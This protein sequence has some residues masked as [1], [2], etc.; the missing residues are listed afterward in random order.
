LKELKE[1]YEKKSLENEISLGKKD[2][3]GREIGK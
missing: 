3:E 2:L 1:I